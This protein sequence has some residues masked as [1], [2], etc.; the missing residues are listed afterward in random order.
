MIEEFTWGDD[1]DASEI[2]ERLEVAF[3]SCDQIIRL[4][5]NGAFEDAMVVCILYYAGKV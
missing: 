4:R 2:F 5:R 3:V 1:L